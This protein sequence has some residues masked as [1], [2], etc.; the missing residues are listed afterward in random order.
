MTNWDIIEGNWKQLKGEA[1]RQW[2]KLTD[3]EWE[4]VAGSRD[5]L[6]GK[7]QE[8]YGWTH[9]EAEQHVD[10]FSNEHQHATR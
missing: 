8:K 9:E 5:K 6:V 4:Q 1:R 2:G 10:T 3:D 7:L